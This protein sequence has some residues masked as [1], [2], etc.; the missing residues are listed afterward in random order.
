MKMNITS[1]YLQGLELNVS[2]S[3]HRLLSEGHPLLRRRVRVRLAG[4]GV[5]AGLSTAGA[6]P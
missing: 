5:E 2:G 4:W 1:A 6:I 3:L